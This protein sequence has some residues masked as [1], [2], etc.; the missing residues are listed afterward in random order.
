ME[1]NDSARSSFPPASRI[2]LL[3][4]HVFV[5]KSI[6]SH[7]VLLLFIIHA[8]SLHPSLGVSHVHFRFIYFPPSGLSCI[9]F[10]FLCNLNLPSLFISLFGRLSNLLFLPPPCLS[11]S[12]LPFHVADSGWSGAEGEGG[13][14]RDQRSPEFPH[15]PGCRCQ[16]P[17][18][19]LI[20]NSPQLLVV[21]LPPSSP[22]LLSP[23]AHSCTRCH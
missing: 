1:V 7:A 10:V 13:R 15:R 3:S 19:A 5:K 6:L 16:E 21:S 22:P 8:H 23:L 11:S 18:G 14:H 17:Q 9:S 20:K 4:S 2:L 12:V